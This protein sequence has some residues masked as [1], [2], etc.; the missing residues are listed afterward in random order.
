MVTGSNL[1]NY[2]LARDRVRR[3]IK[4]PEKLT[5]YTQFAFA[6]VMAEEVESEEPVC[7]H[8]AKEDKDWKKWH[9]GMSEE[10]DSLW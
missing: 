7:F 2:Q 8:D 10:M 9:G 4:P 6:L 1:K 5:D 3:T